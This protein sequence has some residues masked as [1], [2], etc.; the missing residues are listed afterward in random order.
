MVKIIISDRRILSDEEIW[1]NTSAGMAEMGD[2]WV[3]KTHTFVV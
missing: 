3:L 2:A 1:L